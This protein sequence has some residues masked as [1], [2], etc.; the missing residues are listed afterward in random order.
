MNIQI[1]I[2]LFSVIIY[3]FLQAESE[4]EIESDAKPDRHDL[5][6]NL[7][8]KQEE[9]SIL[10]EKIRQKDSKIARM[11]QDLRKFSKTLDKKS[12]KIEELKMQKQIPEV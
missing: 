10:E 7:S 6:E 9:I 11:K 12:E 4:S 8:R 1:L 3:K 5:V 2:T